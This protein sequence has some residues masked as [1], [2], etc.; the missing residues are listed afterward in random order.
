[1]IHT[2]L[3]CVLAALLPAALPCQEEDVFRAFREPSPREA[4]IAQE[5]TAL[6]NKSHRVR[7]S[8]RVVATM[9]TTP[10]RI[11]LIEPAL[12][13]LLGQSRALEALYLFVPHVFRRDGST[14]EM[15]AWLLSKPGVTLVRCEDA[16]PATHM[17][18]V[19]RAERE[20]DTY[21]LQVD[22]D[23]RYGRELLENLLRATGP[24]P[25]RAIGA[26]TQ[27]AHTYLSGVVL[28]GVHGVLFQRKFFDASVFDFGGFSE[29]CRL[30]DDLWLSAHLAKRAVERETLAGRFGTKPL[31]YGFQ[32][33]ALYR[34][35]AGSDNTKNFYLC[36]ASLLRVHPKL[37]EPR[38]RVVVAAPLLPGYVKDAA[39]A[40][41]ALR[42]FMHMRRQHNGGPHAL[43]L[44]GTPPQAQQD[45]SECVSL[46]GGFV[47]HV[48]GWPDDLDIVVH[49][50]GPGAGL[51]ESLRLT[52]GM[53][54][55]PQTIIVIFNSPPAPKRLHQILMWHAG[56]HQER[57]PGH[58]GR[59]PCH[60][61]SGSVSLRR[62]AAYELGLIPEGVFL[63]R[64]SAL[65]E[66]THLDQRFLWRDDS[67]PWSE[68][69]TDRRQFASFMRRA[70]EDDVVKALRR[71]TAESKRRIVAT[72]GTSFRRLWRLG[73]VISSLLRQRES[74]LRIY[75]FVSVHR[76]SRRCAPGWLQARPRVSTV[77][78]TNAGPAAAL[79]GILNRETL[80][81]TGVLF[82]DDAH[83]Y[84]T[85]LLEN[86]LHAS[87]LWP[88][89]A[90]GCLGSSFGKHGGPV[91]MSSL[92]VL[93]YR[94]FL[95]SRLSDN[96]NG[97]CTAHVDMAAAAHL[98]LE[99][100]PMRLV[101][102]TF[103]TRRTSP[104]PTV[105][106]NGRSA[107]Y[108]HLVGHNEFLWASRVPGRCVLFVSLLEGTDAFLLELTIRYA[109]LQTRKPD[110][111]V[112]LAASGGLLAKDGP[113]AP[114]WQHRLPADTEVELSG[115]LGGGVAR[116]NV[117]TGTQ[118]DVPLHGF[119][120]SLR[121]RAG[122]VVRS[123]TGM[124]QMRSF[125]LSVATCADGRCSVRPALHRSF[126]LEREASTALIYTSA[127]R[128]VNERLVAE[129]LRCLDGCEPQCGAQHWCG[130]SV[131]RS[132][133]APYDLTI[134][135][136]AGYREYTT[137]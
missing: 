122:C 95:D 70:A 19:L 137:N 99:G 3:C 41:T 131:T 83:R 21:I 47:Q 125:V 20:P 10:R 2:C 9:T 124:G 14:Y 93:Y 39:A 12:D 88:G 26:G 1:M 49:D 8:R 98:A 24:L 50:G 123:N 11:A 69:P 136:M 62:H 73:I 54:E 126:E 133:G 135:R 71:E 112:L 113:A 75:V 65:H 117:Q 85:G 6:A 51:E 101:G 121:D 96:L 36:I 89:T 35:G 55:D 119:L 17:L 78:V 57:A 77:C 76:R 134:R 66:N 90:V 114:A 68:A 82:C 4:A 37:F 23:Q 18:E 103:G 108:T 92:G 97:P 105:A 79:L 25:G 60:G 27:H 31:E 34:G 111:V 128:L 33:D 87:E 29:S 48:G 107:C 100:V 32:E 64:F 16:G 86:L 94:R 72:L 132:D 45:T 40:K 115:P 120:G 102:E 56:C 58:H 80:P 59:E 106:A 104:R 42:R 129:N 44:M 15:P 109:S 63:Q 46:R 5:M 28:E 7:D 53:E 81:E 130:Q 91:A 43:Y 116:I 118:A 22:D 110:E 61:A 84:G 67:G 52:L 127:E 30:H 74:I 38:H 13:S